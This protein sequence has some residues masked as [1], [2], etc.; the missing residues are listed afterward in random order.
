MPSTNFVKYLHELISFKSISPCGDDAIKYL[1][2]LLVKHG[3]SA[4][5][6]ICGGN[7]GDY[8]VSNLYASYGNAK[9]NICFAGHVDVVPPGDLKL[10]H[11][12]PFSATTH[13]Q[14]IYGRGAVDMKGAIACALD[15]SFNF[16]KLHNKPQG[17]ISFLITSDE[18]KVAKHG[19]KEMLKH[20]EKQQQHIDFAIVGEPTCEQ[21]IGDVIKIGRRGSIN[22]HLTV[23]GQQGH[24]AYPEQAHNPVHDLINIIKDLIDLQFDQGTK[25]FQSS[26]LVVT[27]VDV[28]NYVTNLTPHQASGRF[29][30]RFNDAHSAQGI[31]DLVEVAIARRS[32]L[33]Q[34]DHQLSA[35]VFI[36]KP[37]NFIK[38]FA[39]IVKKAT[40]IIPKLSTSG[41]TSD[42][43]FI[44]NYCQ[45]AEF[46]LLSK[47]AHQANE[48]TKIDDLQKLYNVYYSSL[49]K[50]L[51]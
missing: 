37:Q 15:A 30:V 20:L 51:V 40:G 26:S 44:Y 33:Y 36:Q 34:L 19:T 27:S 42:A 13:D 2:D 47:T 24:V 8:P 7:D 23:K 45:V 25:F 38:D 21:K 49:C 41:G 43:R 14:N 39:D 48:C 4:E 50:F 12:D 29:N 11:T 6:K 5:I 3:F 32:N 22:F 46:G 16:L 17:A 28:G 35:N 10:W 1:R 9:P 31:I 18:E